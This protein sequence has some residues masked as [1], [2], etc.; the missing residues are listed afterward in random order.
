MSIKKALH[1]GWIIP[2]R[3]KGQILEKHTLVIEDQK[4]VS[5]LPT[6]HWKRRKKTGSIEESDLNSC[7][8]I[9]GFVNTHTHSP[10]SLLRG[11]AEE[12]PLDE[13]LKNHIWP[14]EDAFVNKE[15]VRD[16]TE[17]SI[18]EMLLSGTTCFNDMY[19]FGDET[20][21]ISIE[22]GIRACIGMI[23]IKF[24]STWASSVDE[25]FQKGQKIHDDFRNHPLIS[26]AF[27]PHAPYTIDDKSLVRIG[28]LA[29]E[30]DVQIHMHI[31]E[32]KEEILKSL[33]EFGCSPIRRLEKLGLLSSRLTG[34]H[35]TEIS[36]EEINLI[37]Q[38]GV[39]V[40]HCPKSNLKLG[41]G[42]APIL[43]MEQKGLN[44]ALGTD[45]AA[46]NNELDMLGEAKIASL[47]AKGLNRSAKALP[48][49]T[50]L[51]MATFNGAKA[52]GLEDEIGSLE[53]GKNADLL[54]I[55]MDVID[56][57]PGYNPL[58]QILYSGNKTQI[59]NVWVNGRQLVKNRK[60]LTIDKDRLIEKSKKWKKRI[61]DFN[62]LRAS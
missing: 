19:F 8:L 1:A 30:L 25:Y 12:L 43:A 27:A 18:A 26:C 2:V 28:T 46:S 53:V 10:M 9:P 22:T 60:L 56:N 39:N 29:E 36:D 6:E 37:A 33:E 45:S 5:I 57:L 55:E 7:A 51:E 40:A 4:I 41:C 31:Q 58:V 44:I 42:I 17:L 32:T 3:P 35:L 13:W 59:T 11:I 21:R 15:F 20:A 62:Q 54:A 14:L 48:A 23:V 38:S 52:L 16:G 50:C 61:F 49:E 34:V 47:L 24:P